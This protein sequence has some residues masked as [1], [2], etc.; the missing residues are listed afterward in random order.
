MI[1]T[2]EIFQKLKNSRGLDRQRKKLAEL[3]N[4]LVLA[5]PNLFFRISSKSGRSH[6]TM[7]VS[8]DYD[9]SQWLEAIKKL[10]D[11]NDS[12]KLAPLTADEMQSWM[13]TTRHNLRDS[14]ANTLSLFSPLT[15]AVEG[16]NVAT[17][18]DEPPVIGDVNVT[19]MGLQ[20]LPGA[21]GKS[22][23]VFPHRI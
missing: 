21:A 12:L 15:L 1:E 14:L 20:G 7:A 10:K 17:V 13:N 4:Q 6:H 18:S 16:F 23:S 9:R 22:G 2:D 3:E 19:I 5:S 8:S 11:T